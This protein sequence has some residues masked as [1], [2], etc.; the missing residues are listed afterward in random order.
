MVCDNT[1]QRLDRI[2]FGFDDHSHLQRLG[3]VFI[4]SNTQIKEYQSQ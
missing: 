1:L 3:V 2:P 4:A